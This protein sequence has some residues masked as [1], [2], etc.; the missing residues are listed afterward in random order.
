MTNTIKIRST[1]G[2]LETLKTGIHSVLMFKS[3]PRRVV[4]AFSH[5][6]LNILAKEAKGFRA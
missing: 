6:D 4:A 2:L 5:F 3:E 1:M